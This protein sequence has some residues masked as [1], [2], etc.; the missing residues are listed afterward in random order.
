MSADTTRKRLGFGAEEPQHFSSE[1]LVS[2]RTGFS[3]TCGHVF[4][5]SL[6][7]LEHKSDWE[8][9]GLRPLTSLYQNQRNWDRH[10]L[11]ICSAWSEANGINALRCISSACLQLKGSSHTTYLH[12]CKGFFPLAFVFTFFMMYI[13]A[14]PHTCCC[15]AKAQ[16]FVWFEL[17]TCKNNQTLTN[18]LP[19]PPARQLPSHPSLACGVTVLLP[20]FPNYLE[21]ES[22]HQPRPNPPLMLISDPICTEIRHLHCILLASIRGWRG[23]LQ[24]PSLAVASQPL[25]GNPRAKFTLIQ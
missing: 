23:H 24:V 4:Q 14:Y 6:V 17:L 10:K 3:W 19:L 2:P 1:L 22:W 11:K 16:S 5:S 7:I 8:L 12:A 15:F 13:S 18:Y 9:L 20:L 21:Q 25:S